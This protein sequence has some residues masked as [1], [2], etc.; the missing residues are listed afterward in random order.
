MTM[1]ATSIGATDKSTEDITPHQVISLLL[2]GALARVDSAISRLDEGE[3]DEAAVLVKKTI[4]IVGGLRDS[5][6]ME[7][8]GDI[9]QNLDILYEYIVARLDAIS[10][11]DAPIA[12]LDEVRVLLAEVHAGWVGISKDIA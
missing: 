2:D 10:D 3:I 4:G 5:L 1:L 7:A 6:D 12:I 8:G 9:A 11:E